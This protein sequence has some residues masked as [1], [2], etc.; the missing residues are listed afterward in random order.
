MN[1]KRRGKLI[2]AR[3]FFPE[4]KGLKRLH[5]R[6]AHRTSVGKVAIPHMF[7]AELLWIAKLWMEKPIAIGLLL[8]LIHQAE[9]LESP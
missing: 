5:E 1:L 2:L 3:S 9:Y 8:K 6:A 7:S 4:T